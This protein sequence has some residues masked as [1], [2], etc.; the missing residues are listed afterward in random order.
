MDQLD[1]A[2]S[3]LGIIRL[4]KLKDLEVRLAILLEG[5]KWKNLSAPWW[6][7]KSASI[8]GVD[9]DGNFILSKS[10]GEIVLWIH[11]QQKEKHISSKL[12]NMLAMLELDHTNV[13]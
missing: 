13:P 3:N 5:E 2:I 1:K 4:I 6:K 11:N 9:I 8:V 10:G 12:S 7:G